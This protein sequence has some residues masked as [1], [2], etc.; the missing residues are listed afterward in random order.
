M[1]VELFTNTKICNQD[2]NSYHFYMNKYYDPYE[3]HIWTTEPLN[4]SYHISYKIEK[5]IYG[6]VQPMQQ[7][8][9]YEECNIYYDRFKLY[10]SKATL[11]INKEFY[12]SDFYKHD[13]S[14]SASLYVYSSIPANTNNIYLISYINTNN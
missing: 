5:N 12:E 9:E 7:V 11:K 4:N 6:I 14:C 1:Q 10:K 8:T 2:E 3:L 13:S